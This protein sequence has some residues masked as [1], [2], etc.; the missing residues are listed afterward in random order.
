MQKVYREDWIIN[1]SIQ[2]AAHTW[3]QK[4]LLTTEQWLKVQQQFPDLFYNPSLGGKIGLFLFTL[5]ATL[6][7]LSLI[8]LLFGFGG[9]PVL[10]LS[11][12]LLIGSL[13]IAIKRKHLFHSG[14]D[15]ALLFTSIAYLLIT[16][17]SLL[18]SANEGEMAIYLFIVCTLATFRYADA[19]IAVLGLASLIFA[20]LYFAHQYHVENIFLPF[21][22]MLLSAGVYTILVCSKYSVYYENCKQYLLV[23]CYL[24]FYLSGNYLI[25][26]KLNFM[27]AEGKQISPNPLAVDLFFYFFTIA[28]PLGYIYDALTHKKRALLAVGILTLAFSSYTFHEKFD[29]LPYEVALT[30]SGMSLIISSIAFIRYL[31]KPK[32]GFSDHVEQ[33]FHIP[34]ESIILAQQ[35]KFPSSGTDMSYGGGDFGGGGAGD[36]Y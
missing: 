26:Q 1:R 3:H 29:L 6:S 7:V 31:K 10:M 5:V 4:G 15:T 14:I 30:V 32:Y 21:L 25:V 9:S 18:R 27:L 11:C 28:V 22:G 19:T 20:A 12:I 13:E 17:T 33:D 2:K 16:I 34:I 8:S 23:C 24:I 35:A 36:N